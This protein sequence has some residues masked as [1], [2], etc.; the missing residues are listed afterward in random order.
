MLG[1]YVHLWSRGAGGSY[2]PDEQTIFTGSANRLY[3]VNPSTGAF[4]DLS[5]A[6]GPP[7][8]AAVG[9]PA[10][11]RFVT[12]GNDIFATN[13]LDAV[14][15]RTNNAGN[16]ANGFTSTFL[17][18]PR[19]M[20]AVR[21]HLVVANLANAGRFQD[22]I[23]WSDADNALNFDPP[24]GS[25]T[26][27][28]GSKRLTSIPGQITGLLGGQF[29]LVFKAG[30][31]FYLE[32]TGTA[33]VFRPDVL[34]DTVGTMYP[35][36]IIR[37][38]HGVFFLGPDGFYQISGLSEPVKISPPGVDEHILGTSFSAVPSSIAAYQEDTQAEAFS[39]SGL[40]VIGWA[41][42][43]DVVGIGSTNVVLYDPILQRWGHGSVS[44]ALL[45]AFLRRPRATSRLDTVA[46]FTWDG[47]SSQY[48]G[49]AAS[50]STYLGTTLELNFRPANF[51]TGQMTQ[52]II[53]GIQPV[54]SGTGA[55][56]SANNLDLTVAVDAG[57]H[58]FQ[59]NAATETIATRNPTTGWYD[60]Q[61]VGR[62][63]R[64]RITVNAEEFESFHGVW[65]DQR[66]LT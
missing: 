63:F 1:S 2:T 7:P 44:P 22:E 31:I 5:R 51:E 27:I 20:A 18:I 26:S 9:T 37:T 32:Y 6:A 38:Q 50:G 30:G 47:S 11:W 62:L 33:Q 39:L 24:T 66:P 52:S 10:G 8:Y 42:R 15:R 35:S 25:S 54:F 19:F 4:T 49:Y 40:P 46:G 23:A 3:T 57:L 58:S 12:I 64:V 13:W 16:F 55:S 65:I 14:Q 21:E 17:P 61:S 45:G 59:D 29:G 41:W 48:A 28:A 56:L 34:S 53:S 36:S 60:L 43:S